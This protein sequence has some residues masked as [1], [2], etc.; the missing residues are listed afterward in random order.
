MCI[1][2]GCYYERDS[3]LCVLP[4][5]CRFVCIYLSTEAKFKIAE[6]LLEESLLMVGLNYLDHCNTAVVSMNDVKRQLTFIFC[7]QIPD[8]FQD[9]R[10]S[11]SSYMAEVRIY[12]G[13]H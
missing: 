6:A 9:Y 7:P 10:S 1:L 5:A 11:W 4:L 8:L 13:E 12:Q 2:I 3:F